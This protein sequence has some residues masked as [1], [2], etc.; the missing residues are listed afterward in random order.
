MIE[1]ERERGAAQAGVAARD[2]ATALV[3]M[4]ERVLQAIFIEET[5]A[6]REQ[7]VLDTLTHVWRSAIYGPH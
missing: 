5:P 7:A 6:V 4:N 3:Q 2:L 1:A